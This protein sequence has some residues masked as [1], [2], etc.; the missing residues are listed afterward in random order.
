MINSLCL[1]FKS[2]RM[3]IRSQM[4][5]RASFLMQTF[6]QLVMMVTELLAVLILMDR[7][8]VL[9][10]WNRGEILFF[11]GVISTSFY[12]CECFA[13]GI[14]QFPPLIAQG[15]LDSMLIRPRGVLFQVICSRADPRRFVDPG[16]RKRADSLDV[17]QDAA[18]DLDHSGRHGAGV[19]AVSHR[20]HAVL[21]LRQA[22]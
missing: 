2:C 15:D 21:L 9:G 12:L 16:Q 19:R 4:Q 22:H 7:F 5:Y 14:T 3:L 10:Q 1:Y 13:R 8:S 20:S 17:L 6:T 18:A 11:F